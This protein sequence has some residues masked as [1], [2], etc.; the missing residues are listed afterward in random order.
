[1]TTIDSNQRLAAAVHS[2][3]QAFRA[4]RGQPAA[5]TPAASRSAAHS[6]VRALVAQ[7]V[8]AL[9]ADDPRRKHKAVRIFLE[10]V[11]LYE[12]GCQLVQDPCFA[13][14]V[15]AVQGQ[16]QGDPQLGAALDQLGAFL[17][18]A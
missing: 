18:S 2:E 3:V 11:L 8:Q 1:M 13:D 4:R 16:M 17:L 9:D 5:P 15:D 7:R 12:L 10:S 14:M 6:G